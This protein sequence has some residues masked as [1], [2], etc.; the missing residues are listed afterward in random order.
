MY[1][2]LTGGANAFDRQLLAVEDNVL[3]RLTFRLR[4]SARAG[5]VYELTVEDAV[6][7]ASDESQSLAMNQGTLKVKNGKIVVGD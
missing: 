3:L 4:G 5:D 6:F 2:D 1:L 7:A